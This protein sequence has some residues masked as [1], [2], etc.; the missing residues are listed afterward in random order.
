[1]EWVVFM[2][3][4][5]VIGG[6]PSGLFAALYASRESIHVT[7][8]DKN[9]EPLKKLL[10]TGNGKCNFW[11]Q[12]NRLK[13]FH[14]DYDTALEHIFDASHLEEAYNS[15]LK[16]GIIPFCKEQYFY[17]YSM[18]SF[19]VKHAFLEEAKQRN[20]DFVL[21]TE[22]INISKGENSFEVETSSCTYKADAVVIA[23]GSKAYPKTGSSGKGYDFASSFGHRIVPVEPSLVALE[24]Q[25]SF[26]R[27]WAGIRSHVKVSY[28]EFEEEGE[29]QLTSSGISGICVFQLSRYVARDLF[30]HQKVTVFIHFLPFALDVLSFLKEQNENVPNRSIGNLLEAVLNYKLVDVLLK[31]CGIDKNNYL[32]SLSDKEVQCLVNMLSSFPCEI[33]GTKGFDSAQVCSGGV[34]LEEIDFHTMESKLVERLFFAGEVLDIDGDCGGY[35]LETAFVSGML[36]GM[37]IVQSFVHSMRLVDFAFTKIKNREKDIE[38]RLNDE[39]RRK[40]HVGDF[41]EFEHQS[42]HEKLRT[43]VIGIHKFN[44]FED[45]FS[46]FDYKRLGLKEEDTYQ[47]MYQFYTLEE[48]NQYG[49]LGIEVKLL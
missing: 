24:M 41:I 3:E 4:V 21:N 10:L 18:Q 22:V 31:R 1:M 42:T 7:V 25:D 19:T 43:Q 49:A 47:M 33:V 40:I 29:I 26:L 32:S 12:D 30:K 13:H 27:D 28:Q 16:M 36:A 17:P 46:S 20:I 45:L 23:T 34:C 5:L 38:I 39:K 2:K 11:N 6:G 9:K 44:R 35:N 8:I 15:I 37:G 48:E 14:S